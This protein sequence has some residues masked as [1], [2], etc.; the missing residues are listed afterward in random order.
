[1]EEKRITI[2]TGHFGSGK[3]ELSIRMALNS[4]QQ[5]KT[6]LLDL[7]V[8]NPFFRTNEAKDV[9]E[10]RGVQV[11]APRFATSQLDIPALTPE[12]DGAFQR[13]DGRLIVDVGGDEDG[14]R[15]LGRYRRQILE[16][17][18]TMSAV[19][20]LMRPFTRNQQEIVEMV[21]EIEAATGL[22]VTELINNTHLCSETTV[23]LVLQGQ[24]E[25]EAAARAL[26]LETPVR[27]AAMRPWIPDSIDHRLVIEMDPVLKT[28]WD[29]ESR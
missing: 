2:L 23:E 12:L 25:S 22:V 24:R 4:C 26:G 13:K 20:N 15:V 14:A 29:M 27:L 19:V 3:T 1:M 21:R 10:K 17:G 8:V 28:P 7:D 9:L 5:Q 6:I 11:L 16:Q 18:Y